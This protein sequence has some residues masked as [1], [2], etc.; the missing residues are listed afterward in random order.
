MFRDFFRMKWALILGVIVLIL[1][2]Y[3]TLFA[4]SASDPKSDVGMDAGHYLSD[5]HV[6]KVEPQVDDFRMVW[7]D[8]DGGRYGSIGAW[9]RSLEQGEETLQFAMNGGMYM[10][11]GE[12]VGLYIEKGVERRRL[13]R[14][15][16]AKGNFYMQPNGVLFILDS[17]EAGICKT[18]DYSLEEGVRYATQ[19]GPML[20]VDGK[21]NGHFREGSDSRFIRNGVGL[22]D[23]GRLIFVMSKTKVN[24]YD[25]ATCFKEMG[26]K[27][28]LYLDGFVSRMYAPS[29]GVKNLDGNFG[30]MLGVVE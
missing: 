17:G 18:A 26:C 10:A 9:K 23:D 21:L 19:S 24:F 29:A 2:L 27:E 28:A 5:Y 14:T 7:G 4:H 13:N 20:L 8:K 15:T 12:P 6:Y 16:V 22:L 30:V 11:S 3:Y 1:G 25:F